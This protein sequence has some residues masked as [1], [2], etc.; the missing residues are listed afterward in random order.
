MFVGFDRS[1]R[2]QELDE[3]DRLLDGNLEQV[4][5]QRHVLATL[6]VGGKANL[7]TGFLEELLLARQIYIADRESMLTGSR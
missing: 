5:E 1:R 3:L 7:V 2:I 6:C 4:L